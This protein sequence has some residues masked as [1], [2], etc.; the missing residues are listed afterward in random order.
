MVQYTAKYPANLDAIK[1]GDFYFFVVA[2]QIDPVK[3][4]AAAFEAMMTAPAAAGAADPNR[5]G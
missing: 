1:S 4:H 3:I 2:G 5:Q